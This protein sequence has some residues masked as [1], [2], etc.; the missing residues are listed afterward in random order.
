MLEFYLYIMLL[1]IP[2]T[3]AQNSFNAEQGTPFFSWE[4]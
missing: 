4:L 1:N 3:N 2:A